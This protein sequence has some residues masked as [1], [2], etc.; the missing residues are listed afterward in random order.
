MIYEAPKLNDN[1]WL[2]RRLRL[3][4]FARTNTL[5][6]TKKI[7]PR[8]CAFCNSQLLDTH[9]RTQNQSFASILPMR[10]LWHRWRG[11]KGS[12]VLHTQ[13]HIVFTKKNTPPLVRKVHL[14][15]KIT[16]NK[17]LKIKNLH[18]FDYWGG[19]QRSQWRTVENRE[20]LAVSSKRNFAVRGWSQKALMRRPKLNSDK[21]Q[22]NRSIT[23]GIVIH[24]LNYDSDDEI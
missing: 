14:P 17:T 13:A 1:E 6:T 18:V 22:F 2:V 8:L 20:T 11:D 24:Y 12:R 16:R 15:S 4:S 19:W 9:Q 5:A 21:K 23:I 3:S 7:F 10:R